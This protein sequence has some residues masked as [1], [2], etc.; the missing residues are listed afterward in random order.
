MRKFELIEHTAD[1]GVKVYGKS[2]P[3]VFKHAADALYYLLLSNV[4]PEPNKSH[5][6]TLEAEKTDEL[7]VAW[8]NELIGLLFADKFLPNSYHVSIEDSGNKKMLRCILRGEEFD[9]SQNPLSMEVKAATYHDLK[10]EETDA[11]YMAQ[12]IFD[13]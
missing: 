1:V 11:G 12:V 7:L 13:V 5:S 2:L 4:T 10:I 9:P 3:E 8:L 6:I